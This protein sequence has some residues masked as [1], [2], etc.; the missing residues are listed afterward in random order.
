MKLLIV[1]HSY[2]ADLKTLE[3][4][5]FQ[6]GGQQVQV[7][8]IYKRGGSYDTYLG[9]LSV[10]DRITAVQA[11]VTLVILGGNSISNNR[12]NAE[13]YDSIRK[14]YTKLRASSPTSRI[15]AAQVELRFYNSENRW[16]CPVGEDYIKRRVAINNFLKRLKLKDNILMISGVNRL[17]NQQYYKDFVL[18]MG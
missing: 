9:D 6:T 13:I 15:A 16:D 14:F 12:T 4:K 10:F 1:G 3:V 17:D 5:E 18:E 2:V 11:D 7:T 8:Y